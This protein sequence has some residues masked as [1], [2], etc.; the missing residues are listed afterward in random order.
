MMIRGI[1]ILFPDFCFYREIQQNWNFIWLESHHL[2]FTIEMFFS[3]FCF[4]LSHLAPRYSNCCP[5]STF[6]STGWW[7]LLTQTDPIG[8]GSG[9]AAI[10][11]KTLIIYQI[12]AN[13]STGLCPLVVPE[14]KAK[15]FIPKQD[16]LTAPLYPVWRCPLSSHSFWHTEPDTSLLPRFCHESAASALIQAATCRQ[17]PEPV[18]PK[19]QPSVVFLLNSLIRLTTRRWWWERWGPSPPMLDASSLVWRRPKGPEACSLHS[20]TDQW[21][22]WWTSDALCQSTRYLEKVW[23]FVLIKIQPLISII[24]K[25]PKVKITQNDTNDGHPTEGHATEGSGDGKHDVRGGEGWGGSKQGGGNKSHQNHRLTS[26]SARQKNNWSFSR[27]SF[28]MR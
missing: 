3:F 22:W 15:L 20:M 16:S 2:S 24:S 9:L 6:D 14:I 1:I 12:L 18:S 11:E 4:S 26:K 19:Q 7:F 21:W 27:I 10:T 8:F 25:I 13:K 28:T 17:T 23:F 5:V